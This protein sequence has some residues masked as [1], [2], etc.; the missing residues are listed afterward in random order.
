MISVLGLPLSEAV[1]LL[2]AEGY[3]VE[4]VEVSSKKGV[5]GNERRIVRQKELPVLPGGPKRICLT[6]AVF[7]TDVGQS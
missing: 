5:Q 2:E 1:A 6:Y 3:A 7:L 4:T